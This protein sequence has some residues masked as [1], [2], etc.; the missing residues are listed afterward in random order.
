MGRNVLIADDDRAMRALFVHALKSLGVENVMVAGD[1]EEALRFFDR[2]EFDLILLD[3]DMPK[4]TGLE[5]LR[6]IR[7]KPSDAPVIMITAKRTKEGV[8]EAAEAGVTDYLVKPI[9]Q[10]TLTE[11]LTRYCHGPKTQIRKSV[12]RCGNVMNSNAVSINPGA[13]IGEAVALL[14][15]HNISGL[16]VVDDE[17]RLLGIVTE[18]NLLDAITRPDLKVESV[19]NLMSTDVMTVDE[20]TIPLKV[21]TIMKQHKVQRVPVVRDGV[22]VGV[23]SRHDI[24]RY[25]T[26]NEEALRGFLEELKALGTN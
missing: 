24:L 5:V 7:E 1:G 22:L 9:D 26:E 20:N 19:R 15:R 11:K 8:V 2:N 21:V 4:K 16:P 14:L 18:Y 3:W 17:K 13:S 25:L 10:E 12:F 23:I 6:A